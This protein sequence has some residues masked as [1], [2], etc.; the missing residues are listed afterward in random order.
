[1]RLKKF[2]ANKPKKSSIEYKIEKGYYFSN[3]FSFRSKKDTQKQNNADSFGFYRRTKRIHVHFRD[4]PKLLIIVN[5]SKKARAAAMPVILNLFSSS[6]MSNIGRLKDDTKMQGGNF[7]EPIIMV[8]RR[9]TIK[10]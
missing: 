5:I 2:S 6:T 10:K 4:E 8:K 1:M 3:I 7:C 9:N